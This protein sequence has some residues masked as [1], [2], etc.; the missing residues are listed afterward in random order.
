LTRIVLADDSLL[1]REGIA[2]LSRR[3]S[4]QHPPYFLDQR[5]GRPSLAREWRREIEHL[6][7]PPDRS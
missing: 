5:R 4:S 1:V 6:Y 7:W 3:T 2:L